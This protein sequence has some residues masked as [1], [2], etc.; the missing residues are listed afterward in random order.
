M[1]Q[2]SQYYRTA[3]PPPRKEKR[4]PKISEEELRK[5]FRRQRERV[6]LGN[7]HLK[8]ECK[9]WKELLDERR[10]EELSNIVMHDRAERVGWSDIKRRRWKIMHCQR[11]WYEQ[12][13]EEWRAELAMERKFRNFL[14]TEE[15]KLSASQVLLDDCKKALA[16]VEETFHAIPPNTEELEKAFEEWDKRFQHA[17][18]V[19]DMKAMC[20]DTTQSAKMVWES[21]ER[22]SKIRRRK[23]AM[24]YR[25]I[26]LRTRSMQTCEKFLQI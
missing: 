22:L 17:I 5:C 21:W 1:H 23:Q 4:M 12:R 26:M 2:L 20:E 24:Q 18:K 10:K 6:A 13:V 11:L 3:T 19:A 15:E 7:A 16:E 14:T 9:M 25:R 8:E